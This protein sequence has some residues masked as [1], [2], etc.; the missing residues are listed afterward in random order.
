M[1]NE[2]KTITISALSQVDVSKKKKMKTGVC[3]LLYTGE[4][5]LSLHDALPIFLEKCL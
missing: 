2:S 5:T 4:D 1:N 3:Q